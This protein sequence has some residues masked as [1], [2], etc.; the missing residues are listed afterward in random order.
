MISLMTKMYKYLGY[1]LSRIECDLHIHISKTFFLNLIFFHFFVNSSYSLLYLKHQ[2]SHINIYI[3]RT[4]LHVLQAYIVYIFL[5]YD[6]SSII[7]SSM[8]FKVFFNLHQWCCLWKCIPPLPLGWEVPTPLKS[9]PLKSSC[10]YMP[11]VFL[12]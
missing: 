4:I 8:L 5:F 2:R 7:K 12:N 1:Q 9:F 11:K 10:C 3:Y 6:P